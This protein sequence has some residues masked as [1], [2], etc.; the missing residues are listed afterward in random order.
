MLFKPRDVPVPPELATL[1][2]E[3][4]DPLE[5]ETLVQGN[6]GW[7]RER[8]PRIRAMHVLAF[9]DLEELLI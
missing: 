6:R 2:G 3:K 1:L 9:E 7:I 5:T 4:G 8:D